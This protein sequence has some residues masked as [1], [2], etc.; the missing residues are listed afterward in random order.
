MNR[1]SGTGSP[2]DQATRPTA[3]FWIVLE[4]TSRGDRVEYILE[5]DGLLDHLLR[6]MLR[7]KVDTL[8]GQ[9][10]D[11]RQAFAGIG[12]LDGASISRGWAESMSSEE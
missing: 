7:H 2:A 8:R 11:T 1:S 12:C 4:H 9:S 10:A 6:R 5:R 3:V